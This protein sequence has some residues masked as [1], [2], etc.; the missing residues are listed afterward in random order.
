MG[1]YYVPGTGLGSRDIAMNEIDKVSTFLEQ[2]RHMVMKKTIP[3]EQG[4]VGTL[5][6]E[7]ESWCESVHVACG[8]LE[9]SPHGLS[10]P[11]P[12]QFLQ[13]HFLLTHAPHFSVQ[14]H[15]EMSTGLFLTLVPLFTLE[16]SL[17]L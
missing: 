7:Q 3:R 1:T 15:S 17:C 6:L 5:Q 10:G 12:F 9:T 8:P 16:L 14:Q 2:S 4:P 11:H 13:P